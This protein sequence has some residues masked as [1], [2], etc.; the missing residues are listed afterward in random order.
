[1]VGYHRQT[2][3]GTQQLHTLAQEC[4]KSLHLAVDLYAQ[5][6]KHLRK[7]FFG[8]CRVEHGLCQRGKLARGKHRVGITALDDGSRKPACL[9]ELAVDTEYRGKTFFG[10]LGQKSCRRKRRGPVHT[11]VE[12]RVGP[13]REAAVGIVEMVRRHPEVGQYAVD[14]SIMPV[15]PQVVGHIAEVAVHG[16]EAAVGK[17]SGYG[18][19]IAVE[20]VQVP[21]FPQMFHDGARMAAAAKGGVDIHPRR[22]QA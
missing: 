8:S 5:S 6:L 17:G 9:P 11:H 1:M 18:V 22:L 13:E 20:R 3:A 7:L 14:I 12:R 10:S 4:F 19:G 21:V 2:T 15:I 16:R